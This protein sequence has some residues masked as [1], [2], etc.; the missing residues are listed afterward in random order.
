MRIRLV[1]LALSVIG[2]LVPF[3]TLLSYLVAEDW[4][5][6]KILDALFLNGMTVAMFFSFLFATVGLLFFIVLEGRR[7]GMDLDVTNELKRWWGMFEIGL[8][9]SFA[10]CK[11]EFWLHPGDWRTG[12][13]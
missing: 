2:V 13:D 6:D 7:M 12:D 3:F 11:L 9:S 5:L 1:Y 10:E 8:A 4:D